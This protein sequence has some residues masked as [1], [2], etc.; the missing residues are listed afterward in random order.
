MRVILEECLPRRLGAELVGH[1]VATVPEAG[2][3]GVSKGKLLSRIAGNYDAFITI[4]KNLPVQQRTETLPFGV[5]LVRARSNQLSDLRPL[6]PEILVK[7][8]VLKPGQIFVVPGV[9]L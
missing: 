8:A 9:S 1:L 3:A 7:W 6:L 5:I 4:D 2:W